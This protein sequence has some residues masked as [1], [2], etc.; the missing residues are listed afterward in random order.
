MSGALSAVGTWVGTVGGSVA[1]GTVSYRL[2]LGGGPSASNEPREGGHPQAGT[3][4]PPP[5][6]APTGPP[7]WPCRAHTT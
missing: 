7:G 1:E 3:P 5:H 4:A 6:A 2:G